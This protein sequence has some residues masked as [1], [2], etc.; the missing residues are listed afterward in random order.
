MCPS[1]PAQPAGIRVPGIQQVRD[2]LGEDLGT[3]PPPGAWEL[4][5]VLRCAKPELWETQTVAKRALCRV[6][7]ELDGR[8]TL[9]VAGRT[10]AKAC[11]ASPPRP[12]GPTTAARLRQAA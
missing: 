4:L 9:S 6:L 1:R 3:P 5:A 2:K 10:V 8:R 12:A 11:R 7:A